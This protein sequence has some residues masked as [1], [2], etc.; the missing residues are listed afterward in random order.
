MPCIHA[1]V[2]YEEHERGGAAS[3]VVNQLDV[4]TIATLFELYLT[5]L[6]TLFNE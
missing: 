2:A 6:W 4:E 5:S 1:A 3:T